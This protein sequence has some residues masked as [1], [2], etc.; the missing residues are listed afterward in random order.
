M[1]QTYEHDGRITF[2]C[3]HGKPECFGNLVHACAIAHNNMSLTL[4]Q[5][6]SCMIANNRDGLAAA[7]RVS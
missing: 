6:V 3:Q 7:K 4:V 5:Y 1:L 2:D